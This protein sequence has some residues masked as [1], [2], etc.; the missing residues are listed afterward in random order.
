MIPADREYPESL[1]TTT[2]PFVVV[3]LDSDDICLG[4][5]KILGFLKQSEL[6]VS[7]ISTETVCEA[8]L[9]NEGCHSDEV[10]KHSNCEEKADIKESHNLPCRCRHAL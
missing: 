8:S 2:V 5:G 9:T 4:K 1:T 3:N 6:K 10:L 7:E